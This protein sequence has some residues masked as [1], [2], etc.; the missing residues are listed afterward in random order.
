M[1]ALVPA[2]IVFFKYTVYSDC[3][4]ELLVKSTLKVLLC[5]LGY[6]VE[7]CKKFPHKVFLEINQYIAVFK[8]RL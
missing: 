7:L 3:H 1:D 4:A 8:H 2:L 5:V 6:I